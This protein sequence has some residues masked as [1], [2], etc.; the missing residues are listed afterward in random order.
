VKIKRIMKQIDD[1]FNMVSLKEF[2]KN[3]KGAGIER[4]IRKT[5]HIFLSITALV[6]G[7]IGVVC[8]LI[9]LM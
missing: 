7:I 5:I 9:V 3:L 1:H 8:G 2:E 4:G 6:C